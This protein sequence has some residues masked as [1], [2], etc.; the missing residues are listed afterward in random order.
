M[1]I[2]PQYT[3]QNTGSHMLDS[4]GAYGR[5]YDKPLPKQAITCKGD[6]AVLSVSNILSELG[7]IHPLHQAFYKWAKKEANSELDWFSAGAAYMEEKGYT[8]VA[9]DNTCNNDNDLDQEFVF[10]VWEPECDQSGDWIY[11]DNCIVL[12]YC[13]TGCDV[14]GGYSSPIICTFED[15][16]YSMPLDWKIRGYAI[17]TSEIKGDTLKA[18]LIE[19]LEEY[20]GDL[21]GAESIS[22]IE[23]VGLTVDYTGDNTPDHL[24]GIC[25]TTG[26]VVKIYPSGPYEFCM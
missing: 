4:G 25:D 20:N 3:R 7:T 18:K 6:Y 15:C 17:D 11:S 26:E 2:S 23:E 9:R 22:D 8:Q 5:I 13:H 24:Q 10:E 16:D 21:Y 14:R 12:I 19:H 1:T